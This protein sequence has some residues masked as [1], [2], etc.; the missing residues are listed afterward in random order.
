[1]GSLGGEWEEA[2]IV[3]GY[4]LKRRKQQKMEKLL[5]QK[6]PCNLI[7]LDKLLQIVSFTELPFPNWNQQR[8]AGFAKEV[9]NQ[10]LSLL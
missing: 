4:V 6:L 1:M 3:N 8:P 7:L 5:S 10:C 9:T 2:R